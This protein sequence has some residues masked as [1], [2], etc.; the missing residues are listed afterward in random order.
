MRDRGR[1][2]YSMTSSMSIVTMKQSQSESTSRVRNDATTTTSASILDDNDNLDQITIVVP[3]DV[4][5]R[6]GQK[7]PDVIIRTRE[8]I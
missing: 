6:T 4:S 7:D 1:M 2:K 5:G 8:D 3:S